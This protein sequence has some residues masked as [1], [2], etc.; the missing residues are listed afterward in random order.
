MK[1]RIIPSILLLIY[2]II[3]I[4]VMVFKSLPLIRVGHLMLN[5][6][7][8]DGGHPANFIPFKTIIPYLFGFKGL[9]IAGINIIGNIILLVPVGFLIPFI[10]RNIT[11]KKTLVLAILSGLVIETTQVILHVG[12]FDIDDVILNA[13]GVMIGF[14]IFIF[15]IKKVPMMKPIT[16]II[17]AII[18]VLIAA[19]GINFAYQ[20]GLL[21]ISL[22]ANTMHE[23]L[24]TPQGDDLCG[25]TGGN[26][27]VVSKGVNSF[28]MKKNE[29]EDQ[30]VKLSNQ[31][32]IHT[33][34]GT[35][36]ESGLKIGDRVTLVGGPNA[37]GSFTADAVFVCSR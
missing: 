24:E 36:S 22:E 15:L 9:I 35:V 25:G 8:T 14:W 21:P 11:W 16:K 31:A 12:I 23:Q 26:G 18:V 1:K 20:K 10:Y 17:A 37:D 27:Q 13:L 6:A 4:K 34:T 5:F 2:I 7:G 32:T 3:L 30:T 19:L 29:G 28:T 33:S